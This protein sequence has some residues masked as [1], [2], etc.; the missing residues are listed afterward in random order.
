MI[1]CSMNSSLVLDGHVKGLLRH[2]S[3]LLDQTLQSLILTQVEQS[4]MK[5]RRDSKRPGNLWHTW[6]VLRQ[7]FSSASRHLI[8]KS[9]RPSCRF[10]FSSCDTTDVLV[11][12]I[13]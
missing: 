4:I 3:H 9:L 2:F 13:C 11:G 10:K 7:A 12:S 6:E 1:K 5:M 8:S